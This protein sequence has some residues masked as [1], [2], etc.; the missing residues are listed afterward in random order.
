M[1]GQY[2]VSIQARSQLLTFGGT[3]YIFRWARFL[4]LLYVYNKF[5]WAQQIRG[6]LPRMPSVA[7]GLAMTSTYQFVT[8]LSSQQ[9]LVAMRYAALFQVQKTL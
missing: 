1:T 4:F 9:L 8:Q 6:T 7:K 3:K 2:E 5:F